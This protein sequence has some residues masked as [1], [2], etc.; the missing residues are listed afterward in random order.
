MAGIQAFGGYV[1]RLRLPRRAISGAVSWFNPGLEALARGERAFASWDEDSIT[2]AVEAARDCLVSR[3]RAGIGRI[4]LASTTLPN[5]DRQNSTVVKEALN[6]SD[7]IAAFDVAGSQRGGTSSLLDA[8]YAAAG[9]AGP[10][11]CITAERGRH[12][13]GSEAELVAGHA[14]AAM[15]VGPGDGAARFLGAHSV[16]LDFVDHFRAAGE[17]FD[18]SWE[19]RWVRDEGYAKIVPAALKVALAKSG[20]GPSEVDH[21]VMPAPLKGVNANVAKLAGIR[22]EAVADTLASQ[23]GDAGCAQPLVM[24]S[25]VLERAGPNETIVVVG[26]GGGCDVIVLRTTADIADCRPASGI[27]GSLA[28]RRPEESYIKFLAFSGLLELEKGMRAELD[29]KPIL[30]ALYRDRKTVLGL[31]GGK[32][33]V[34][35]N[36]QFPKSRISVSPGARTVDTQEDYPL[37]ERSARV[38]SFTADHLTYTPDPPAHYGT[39]EFE[40]G[41]RLMADLV[42]IDEGELEVGLP[43]R[44]IFRIKALD[45][46]RGFTKYFWKATPDRRLSVTGRNETAV[47]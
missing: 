14:A 34:S 7:D 22:P 24:L 39:V 19:A 11:L 21:F 3:S 23:L 8:F 26:F 36:V 5:A 38:I 1:P 47:A 28:A 18:Y 30:T 27:V 45:E 15:L 2:L 20:V 41:G 6:L 32:C 4:S 12:R 10:V 40:G 13:S 17:R 37:A 31:V 25:H 33:R 46:R 44:M 16:T 9:G 43:V 35:G 42:D 29:Q